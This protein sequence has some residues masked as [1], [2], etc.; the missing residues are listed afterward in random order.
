M[1]SDQGGNNDLNQLKLKIKSHKSCQL[2]LNHKLTNQL[3]P[4]CY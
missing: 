3:L 4:R 2:V 1:E